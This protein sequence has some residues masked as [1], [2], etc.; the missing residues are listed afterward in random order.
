MPLSNR[1]SGAGVA[2]LLSTATAQAEPN[3]KPGLWEIQIRTEMAGMPMQMPAVTT[4]QCIRKEDMVPQTNSSGQE[5]EIRDQNVSNDTVSWRIE[6]KSNDMQGSGAGKIIYH[7]DTFQGQ[8][9]M[10]MQQS[11]MGPM[12]MT[13]KLNG[14]RVGECN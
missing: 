12:T 3:M 7:G 14:T 6:C 9:D 13:Q 1:L 10:T 2:L 5:C 11:G 8:I 4:R